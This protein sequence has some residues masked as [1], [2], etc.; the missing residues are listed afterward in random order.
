M[1]F[2]TLFSFFIF[3]SGLAFSQV[4]NHYFEARIKKDISMKYLLQ[5]PLKVEN[6]QSYP[7]IIFLHGAGERGEDLEM[8]SIHGPM[9]Y[10]REG[11]QIDAFILS[12]LC[13]KNRY[14]DTETVYHLILEV[15]DQY[16]IDESRVYLTGLSMG[17]WGTWKLAM[18]HPDVF[19]A[20][21]PICGPVDYSFGSTA[22]KLKDMPIWVFHGALDRS[23]SIENSNRMMGY[24][25]RHD[26]IPKYTVYPMAYHDSWTET[27][28]NP[29]FYK[30][31]FSN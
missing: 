14:W 20:I 24:L 28:N 1:K 8:V 29:E 21:A 2:F 15:L 7:L 9:K 13:P 4:N 25:K 26:I 31:L 23:V 6:G 18:D 17:G 12:P 27:Y 10:L 11:G 30:W 3:F 16:P 22:Y 19:A 5:E